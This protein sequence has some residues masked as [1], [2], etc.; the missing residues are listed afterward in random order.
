MNRPHDF[1]WTLA[2]AFLATVEA[3]SLSA[4]ARN[5]GASQPTLSR[6]V[7]AFAD[8]LGVTLFERVGRKLI[9]TDAGTEVATH[10]RPMAEAANA[11]ARVASGQARSIDGHIRITASDVYAI[12]LLP[13]ILA[14]L[15]R[16]AP[17]VTV[18]VVATD[19]ITDLRRR[20]ADIAIRNARPEDP[21]LFARKVADDCGGFY[22]SPAYFDQYG[23]PKAP[24]DLNR[25]DFV[26]IDTVETSMGFYNGLGLSLGAEN[27]PVVTRS[28]PAQIAL[29]RAGLG[30]GVAPV[31]LGETDPALIRALQ[32]TVSLPF[33]VWVVAHS[34][35]KTSRRVRLVFDLIA[36]MLPGLISR[37]DALQ[38]QL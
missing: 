20:D 12:H 14:R 32:Q 13:P 26:A 8:A 22:A 16:E 27:F 35:L 37:S 34:D 2:Q 38:P 33:P 1:D 9:L 7:A 15:R 11:A 25:A 18:E 4:A 30:I 24:E 29:V 3:G 28:I 31:H 23:W 17:G 21:V 5:L 19:E 36:D 10:L 6:Q